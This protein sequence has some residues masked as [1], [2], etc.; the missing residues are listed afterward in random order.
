[1]NKLENDP[2]LVLKVGR[3]RR[4]ALRLGPEAG[5]Q[6]RSGDERSYA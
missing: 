4:L 2:G 5:W 1:L 6:E 3:L